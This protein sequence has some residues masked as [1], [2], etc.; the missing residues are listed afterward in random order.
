MATDTPTP[1]APPTDAPEPKKK[2]KFPTAFTVL[3]FV[4]LIV[5]ALSFV[6]K[7]GAYDYIAC[8]DGDPKPIPQSYHEIEVD[9]TLKDKLYDLWLSPVNGLYGIQPDQEVE[10]VAE[11]ATPFDAL[12]ACGFLP[13]D[14]PEDATVADLTPAQQQELKQ[15]L[16]RRADLPE[17]ADGEIDPDSLVILGPKQPIGPYENGNLFGAVQV[18]FFVLAIGAFIT[19]TMA[20][21]ALDA[22]IGRLTHRYRKQGTV[23]IVILMV[24]FSLGGTTYGMA[25][26]TLGFYALIVPI[27][28]A[29][30]Y[31][32]IVGAVVI[33]LGAGV[34]TLASTVNPFATG[35]A[36]A[37][38]SIEL[39]DGIV[40]RAIMYV[41]LTIVTILYVLR[42]ANKVKKDPS[43]SLAAPVEGDDQLKA[44]EANPP[45]MTGRQ[46][47]VIWIFM[48]TFVLMIFSVIPWDNFNASWEDFTLGWY[49]PELAALFLVAAII[50]GLIGKLGEEGM[51]NSIVS[52]MGDF[53][54]A[55]LIIALA[56]GVT[57]IM[58]NAGITDT[59]L[60]ALEGIVSN[61]SGPLF[62]MTMFIVNIPLAF[63]VPSSSG[64]ATL[65]MPIMAPLADFAGVSRAIVVTAYQSASGWVNLFTPTS[66]IVMGG[67]T[68]AKVGYDR[69]LR[70]VWPL[71]V[72]LFVLVCGFL[73][74]GS[75]SSIGGSVS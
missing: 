9:Q 72:I 75:V 12:S 33:M 64:H 24:V 73:A 20:T 11:T 10:A 8:G 7:P 41:V 45:E 42:Y 52:G 37:G 4:L 67:L 70:F 57:V 15:D 54:G 63:L 16:Q 44:D 40:L 5:W 68:L 43:K 48:L 22:G 55:A 3:F 19:V 13:S 65:A 51:V 6:I 66:A 74:F 31:D 32:R 23:L 30:G 47:I 56:R 39:G 34:G 61:L 2:F 62:G 58:N 36:A 71:L 25:E 69:Y 27:F 38:A 21:G 29:L 50:I 1:E 18:F 14:I 28:V 59:V 26:E 53:M 49:F 46:K 35:V 60:N 17:T